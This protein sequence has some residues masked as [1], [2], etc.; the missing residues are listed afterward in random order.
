MGKTKKHT[1]PFKERQCESCEL[2]DRRELR[3]GRPNYCGYKEKQGKDP[4]VR[5]GH[6]VHRVPIEP[7]SKKKKR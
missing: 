5:N 7:K 6:C 1:R 3:K 2:A 4:D